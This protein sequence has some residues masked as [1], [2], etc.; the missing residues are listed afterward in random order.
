[1]HS[2]VIGVCLDL[3]AEGVAHVMRMALDPKTTPSLETPRYEVLQKRADYEVRRYSSYLVAEVSM[4]ASSGP[5]SGAHCCFPF[6]LQ[7]CC[8]AILCTESCV[9]IESG[10]CK[11]SCGPF[12]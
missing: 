12:T 3:Q 2:T 4:P 11:P 1:M 9:V 6:E 8:A 10:A 7:Q 5:A